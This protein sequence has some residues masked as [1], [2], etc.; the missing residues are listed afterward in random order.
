L[1]DQLD[2]ISSSV[3]LP[4]LK[5]RLHATTIYVD[6]LEKVANHA[7]HLQLPAAFKVLQ[8]LYFVMIEDDD[9]QLRKLVQVVD[10]LEPVEG[11]VQ[12]PQLLKRV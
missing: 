3:K 9:P 5:E 8:P 4:K 6:V 7:D 11:K 2:L 1:L 12:L 10:A